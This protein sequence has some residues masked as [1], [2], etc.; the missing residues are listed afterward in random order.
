MRLVRLRLFSDPE[1]QVRILVEDNGPGI[2]DE[3]IDR[4]FQPFFTT[5]LNGTGLGLAT[6]FR[7]V[8]AQGAQVQVEAHGDLGG[9]TFELIFPLSTTDSESMVS[10]GE[11]SSFAFGDELDGI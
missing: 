1:E 2:S 3:H 7:L 8:E 4:V 11:L 5:K 10:L 6:I 9:A